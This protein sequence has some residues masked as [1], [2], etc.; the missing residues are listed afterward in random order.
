MAAATSSSTP[1]SDTVSRFQ[2]PGLNLPLH[3]EPSRLGPR[4]GRL[5]F[6]ALNRDDVWDEY[7]MCVTLSYRDKLLLTDRLSVNDYRL[8]LTPLREFTMLH[9]MDALTDKPG[10]EEKVC[11]GA[12]T[13]SPLWFHT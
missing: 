8:R 3:W 1:P 7:T 5:F 4:Q 12:N 2:L 6:T 9:I 10:W 11:T 13:Q